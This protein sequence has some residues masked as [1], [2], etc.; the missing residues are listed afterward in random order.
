MNVDGIHHTSPVR[1]HDPRASRRARGPA[2]PPPPRWSGWLIA[3]G[4]VLTVLLLFRPVMPGGAVTTL[5]Y[6]QFVDR[7]TSDQVRT[8]T[9]E[10]NGRVTGQ[11]KTIPLIRSLVRRTDTWTRS[12]ASPLPSS[13]QR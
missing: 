5:P 12:P 2:P 10:A 7:V 6:S 8:A 4:L 1:Q 9:I 11:L 13:K 3:I